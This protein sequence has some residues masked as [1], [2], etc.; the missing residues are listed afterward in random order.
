MACNAPI[1]D[2]TKILTVNKFRS[3]LEWGYPYSLINSMVGTL[4]TGLIT[5]KPLSNVDC[6][7]KKTTGVLDRHD[8]FKGFVFNI[9]FVYVLFGSL[10]FHLL[11]W[12]T[13]LVLW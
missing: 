4:K 7:L 8:V 3:A 6:L 2:E 1:L 5:I 13:A 10:V 9:F 12:C 11:N